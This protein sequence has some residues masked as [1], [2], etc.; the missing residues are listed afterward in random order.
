MTRLDEATIVRLRSTTIERTLQRL[1]PLGAQAAWLLV[2]LLAAL[3]VGYGV[4]ST[5]IHTDQVRRPEVAVVAVVAL[6]LAAF[7]F[8]VRTH[9]GYAPFGRWS[10]GAI[11]G[12]TLGAACLFWAA[13]WGDN[14]RIQDDWGQIAVGLF[15]VAMPLYRPVSE[16]VIVALVSAV[17]VGTMAALQSDSLQI[18]TQPAVYFTVAATPV[19]ALALGGCGYTWTLTGETL[20]WREVARAGQARL[21]DELRAA[22]RRM[23][24]Q[25]RMTTLN[26]SAVPFLADV[27][28][29]GRITAADRDRA[30][31]IAVDLRASAVGSIERTWLSETLAQALAPH[32]IDPRPGRGP[33]RVSDP[34][35]LDAAFTEEQRAIVGAVVVTVARLRGLAPD[36]VRITASDPGHPQFVITATVAQPLREVRRQLIP[37]LSALQSL[38]MATSLR[39]ADGQLRV[40]FG[41]PRGPLQ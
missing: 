28:A 30:R 8:A 5:L 3:A 16:V 15:L 24:A 9:P 13:V 36:S 31:Q 6:A 40:G 22:A 38:S 21:E 26:E 29:R 7:V 33:E 14:H 19:L 35:R 11:I 18:V 4:C 20:A 1:D 34:D 39:V 23:I 41:Y 17:V 10:Q 25:E 27:L 37:F 12:T 32:G 2:P